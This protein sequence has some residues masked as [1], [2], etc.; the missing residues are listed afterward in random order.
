[1]P[2]L[3]NLIKT[4]TFINSLNLSKLNKVIKYSGLA[5]LFSTVL[6]PVIAHQP[7]SLLD[8]T[9]LKALAALTYRNNQIVPNGE[10]WQPN[11][12]LI[13]GE[14]IPA[15]K[16]ASLD[17]IQL[18]GYLN[19]NHDYYVAA[20]LSGHS[21]DGESNV[22][23]ENFWMGT[24][25]YLAEQRFQ[26]EGGKMT[27]DVTETLNYH[28][29]TG[30]FSQSPLSAEVLF[31]GHFN[32]IG[33]RLALIDSMDE[34]LISDVSNT[35]YKLGIEVFN[36]DNFPASEGEGTVSLFSHVNYQYQ[37][38]STTAKLWLMYSGAENRVDDRYS[39][40]HNHGV[41]VIDETYFTG[42]TFNTGVYLDATYDYQAWRFG[43]EFEWIQAQVD[44][45]VFTTTQ[46]AN[47]E[48]RYDAYRLLAS[49]QRDLHSI[50]VEY[51]I[52]T[53][54]NKFSQTT[55]L[56]IDS[57]GLNN[58]GFEP[59]RF[60]VAWLYAFHPDFNL[61]TEWMRDESN[62]PSDVNDVFSI[63][64]QWQYDIL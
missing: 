33:L 28:A 30:I 13:G 37:N 8:E 20:K 5:L 52:L 53:A 2:M 7:V 12:F 4:V 38:F 55:E 36:G 29:A 25:F 47:M 14:A 54:Q 46:S 63:G 34:Q 45:Q 56:F 31:G 6:Q 19:I 48:S 23:L 40:G 26:F 64:I 59:N 35:G 3:V 17:D 1:M 61:R 44:G 51:E 60:S 43:T 11:G 32:D 24:E 9:S 15:E 27:T 57:I 58:N 21:H 39:E 42:D 22:E 49:V 62:N 18:Q 41:T 10:I 50:Y 16:G